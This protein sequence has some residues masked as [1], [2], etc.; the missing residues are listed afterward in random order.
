MLTGNRQLFQKQGHDVPTK[1]QFQEHWHCLPCKGTQG[2]PASL[3]P[4]NIA[5]SCETL[6][7]VFLIYNHCAGQPK[8]KQSQGP[9]QQKNKYTM[10]GKISILQIAN[11]QILVFVV[12][13]K[14]APSMVSMRLRCSGLLAKSYH[15]FPGPISSYNCKC[16]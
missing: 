16:R 9:I 13:V 1:R 8:I 10:K 3:C 6:V 5:S 7:R 14:S 15:C 12:R 2:M 4:S 11:D